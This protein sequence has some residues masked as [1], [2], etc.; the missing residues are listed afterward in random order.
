MFFSDTEPFGPFLEI[1]ENSAD[2]L[3]DL[4]L[5]NETDEDIKVR[6][7]NAHFNAVFN[8]IHALCHMHSVVKDVN[9]LNHVICDVELLLHLRAR[10]VSVTNTSE[11]TVSV[12]A[13][14][15]RRLCTVTS[16]S[17]LTTIVTTYLSVCNDSVGCWKI[18]LK[19]IIDVVVDL[20]KE[21]KLNLLYQFYPSIVHLIMLPFCHSTTKTSQHVKHNQQ[22]KAN[23]HTSPQRKKSKKSS[24][25]SSSTSS[26]A[27]STGSSFMLSE[28]Q[29]IALELLCKLLH[30][31]N[32]NNSSNSSNNGNNNRTPTKRS[33]SKKIR[34]SSER[35]KNEAC[36]ATYCMLLMPRENDDEDNEENDDD[37]DSSSHSMYSTVNASSSFNAIRE[38]VKSVEAT[39]L[40]PS[41]I[42]KSQKNQHLNA[43]ASPSTTRK[44]TF[45]QLSNVDDVPIQILLRSITTYLSEVV[46]LLSHTNEDTE[47]QQNR[48][49][50]TTNTSNVLLSSVSFQ[51]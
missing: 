12:F 51:N 41:P 43:G 4:E 36:L 10:I 26:S 20:E 27:S 3:T 24:S 25:S 37:D 11:R 14:T 50:N 22:S 21:K 30:I 18:C 5:D 9:G 23:N 31:N 39:T 32:S 40:L 47:N 19:S 8:A 29:Q 44:L 42:K 15:V 45:A 1:L 35:Q 17:V 34:P 49:T 7:R 16:I 48:T 28:V 38:I 46:S 33:S 13:E 6:E 2:D